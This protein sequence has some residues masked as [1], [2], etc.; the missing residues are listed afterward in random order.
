[1]AVLGLREVF[2]GSCQGGTAAVEAVCVVDLFTA[3]LM[4]SQVLAGCWYKVGIFVL[5][6]YP[7]LSTVVLLYL[8]R[9]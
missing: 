1:M 7:N 8:S 6:R 5:F 4:G 3:G 2:A 9:S